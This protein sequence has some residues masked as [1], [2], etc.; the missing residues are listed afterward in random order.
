MIAN[1]LN[2]IFK[3]KIDFKRNN[4]SVSN[5]YIITVIG[6]FI[7]THIIIWNTEINIFFFQNTCTYMYWYIINDN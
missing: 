3:K 4:Y 5:R 7:G 1:S 2:F 6:Y